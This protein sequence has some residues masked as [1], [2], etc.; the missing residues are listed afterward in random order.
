MSGSLDEDE[1]EP[2]NNT[3]YDSLQQSPALR[4]PYQPQSKKSVIKKCR[5]RTISTPYDVSDRKFKSTSIF[6]KYKC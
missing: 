1:E 4:S 2:S 5:L 6:G 3:V